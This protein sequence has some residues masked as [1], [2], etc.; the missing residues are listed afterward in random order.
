MGTYVVVALILVGLT[1]GRLGVPAPRVVDR[2]T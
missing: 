2:T 1:R